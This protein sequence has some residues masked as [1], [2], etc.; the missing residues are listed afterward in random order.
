M[1]FFRRLVRSNAGKYGALGL[2]LL[3]FIAFAAGDITGSG[4]LGVLSGGSSTQVAKIG[5][6]S[7]TVAELQSRTQ[8]LFERLREQRPELTMAQFIA[9]GGLKQVADEMI[10]MKSLIA[11]GEKH[12]MRVSKKLVDAEIARIPAFQGATGTFDENQFKAMLAQQRISEKE[13]REEF[14]GNIIRQHLLLA[15][16]AGARAPESLVPP[17]AAML[18][19]LREGEVIGVPSAA[20]APTRAATDAELRGYYT[21]HPDEFTLPEQRKLRYILLDRTRFDAQATPTDA[22]LATAY[23]DRAAN[24][25]AR[26]TRD[27]TQLIVPT[28]A[29]AKDLAAKAAGGKSLNDLAKEAGLSA[30][31]LTALDQVG[32]AAQ[33]GQEATKAAFAAS[34]GQLVGPFKVALGWSLVRVENITQIPGKTLEQAKPE[35]IPIIRD[36]KSKQ[37]FADFVNGLD[38]KLGEGATLDEVAKTN[39]LQVVET[40]F[41]TGQGRNLRDPDFKLDPALSALLKPAFAMSAGDDAQIIPVKPDEQ[42][43]VLA[44]GEVVPSGP[45]P[46]DEVRKAAEVSWKLAQGSTQARVAAD[47]L[48][49]LLNKGVAPDEALKQAGVLSPERKP[50]AIRRAELGQYQGKVP[51]PITAALTMRAGSAR[52]VPMDRNAGFI[53]VRLEKITEAD[54]RGNAS[55]MQS[56]RA[57]LANVLGSEYAGQLTAAI[58]KD[59]DVQRNPTA[60]AAVEKALRDASSPTPQQ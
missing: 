33:A 49:A 13:L 43:A 16:G 36:Q 37:L 27:V 1:Q 59:I 18:I 58:E 50:I 14:A 10:A 3:I 4:G 39:N 5:S 25:A 24:F 2:L 52:L 7:V 55:L 8:R 60:M 21:A 42:V 51:A 56:T 19:E 57:G 30:A 23:K 20:F 31:R 9:Q 17:Y 12:G 22:D 32:L 6:Q 47:K 29:Q 45:A 53:V 54:P 46:F 35:L 11:Y 15:A 34:K 28:Q 26:Q 41:I 44:P 48:T 38:G 40:P